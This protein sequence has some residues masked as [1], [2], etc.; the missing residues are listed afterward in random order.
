MYDVVK[1]KDISCVLI[2]YGMMIL[3]RDRRKLGLSRLVVDGKV[4]MLMCYLCDYVQKEIWL[5]SSVVKS[6]IKM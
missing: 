5:W 3:L 2:N 1:G 6:R 4:E